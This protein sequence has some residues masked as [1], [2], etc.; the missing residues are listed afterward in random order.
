MKKQ[1]T[2]KILA[3]CDIC[4]KEYLVYPS[5]FKDSKKHFCSP[6]CVGLW[7][8]SIVGP[9]ASSWKGG[10]PKKVC[11]FC[12]KEYYAYGILKYCSFD[13]YLKSKGGSTTAQC[14]SCGGFFKT[15]ESKIKDGGGKFCSR[16]CKSKWQSTICGSR[17][18]GW[19]GG[20]SP[21]R[22][23][24]RESAAYAEWRKAVFS[25]DGYT[26]V[27]CGKKGRL[28][29][30]HIKKFSVILSDIRQKYPLLS[31]ID[32]AQNHTGLWDI[33]NGITLCVQCHKKEH[34]K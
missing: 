7:R 10:K 25:R 19:R 18:A 14:Q 31:V 3:K 13:C 8:K 12:G 20:I 5:R 11:C 26:C 22:H 15:R 16:K 28:H 17:A 21:D 6:R 33:S 29:A 24:I 9:S 4:G 30:H 2:S 27:K 23:I 32:I 1:K 34:A